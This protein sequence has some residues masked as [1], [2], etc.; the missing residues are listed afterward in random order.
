MQAPLWAIG[1]ESALPREG[2]VSEGA[3]QTLGTDDAGKSRP[4]LDAPRP[5]CEFIPGVGPDDELKRRICGGALGLAILSTM[6]ASRTADILADTPGADETALVGGYRAA[7]ITVAILLGAAALLILTF[8]RRRPSPHS[9][10]WR[11]A[12]TT[13]T[14]DS[15]RAQNRGSRHERRGGVTPAGGAVPRRQCLR[16]RRAAPRRWPL[17]AGR[18]VSRFASPSPS[19]ARRRDG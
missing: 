7:Y 5:L 16:R 3:H 13:S 17:G 18:A 10:P 15:P 4:T 19:F 8:L 14:D 6:A 1:T 2:G 11:P 12:T 9:R